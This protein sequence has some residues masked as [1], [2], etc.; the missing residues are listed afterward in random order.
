[1]EIHGPGGVHGP[2]RPDA[3]SERPSEVDQS[4]TTERVV[5]QVQISEQAQYLEKLSQVP[6]IRHERIVEIQQQI[7]AGAYESIERLEI[8]VEKLLEEL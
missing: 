1:M 5:D 7:E 4:S 2:E 8:A 6:A 3:P